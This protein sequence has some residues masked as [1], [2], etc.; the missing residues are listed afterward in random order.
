MRLFMLR[1][2][3]VH[4]GLPAVHS[5]LSNPSL[6][7]QSRIPSP[8]SKENLSVRRPPHVSLT[9][10]SLAFDSDADN[11]SPF[12]PDKPYEFKALLEWTCRNSSRQKPPTPDQL[13][14]STLSDLYRPQNTTKARS[15]R[16]P[17]RSY[18]L[19]TFIQT[20]RSAWSTLCSEVSLELQS[21]AIKE[22][23]A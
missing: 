15:L 18:A 9:I 6:D 7:S 12:Q 2:A 13:E 22:K 14:D 11:E 3:K 16:H 10:S 21:E 4:P 23:Q 20:C 8:L 19:I 5:T 17:R 1:I